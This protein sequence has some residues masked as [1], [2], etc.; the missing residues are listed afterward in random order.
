MGT[1][2]VRIGGNGFN[3]GQGHR[4]SQA[5][6]QVAHGFNRGKGYQPFPRNRFIGFSH[7]YIKLLHHKAPQTA[8]ATGNYFLLSHET[9]TVLIRQLNNSDALKIN[10]QKGHLAHLKECS[11]MGVFN[12]DLP[13]QI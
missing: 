10:L 6:N 7:I 12:K 9:P 11:R 13:R 5:I 4:Q 8:E 3:R 2:L 1:P